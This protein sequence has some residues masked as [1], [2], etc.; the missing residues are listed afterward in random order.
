MEVKR[1][2]AVQGEQYLERSH[3]NS[4]SW[5][6]LRY[7]GRRHNR[8][9]N[10]NETSCLHWL[11]LLTAASSGADHNGRAVM[12]SNPTRGMDVCVCLFCVCVVLCVG[13]GL[14]TG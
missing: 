6:D 12:G 7:T 10:I 9:F 8:H 2:E 3:A 4:V 1:K 13:S 14:A 5:L 11:Y